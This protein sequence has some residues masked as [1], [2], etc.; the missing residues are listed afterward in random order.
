[1]TAARGFAIIA[2]SGIVFGCVGAGLGYLL[3]LVAPDYYGTVFHIPPELPINSA[4]AGLGLGVTEGLAADLMVGA[5]ILVSVPWY[6]SR[7]T[8]LPASA[9]KDSSS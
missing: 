6:R 5:V 7:T 1:M 4:Q 3:G 8:A 2:I 9:P